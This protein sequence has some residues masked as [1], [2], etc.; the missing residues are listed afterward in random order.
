MI[1][2]EDIKNNPDIREYIEAADRSLL[3]LGF[4]EH[5]FSHTTRASLRP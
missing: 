3:A 2:F 4:T 5:G 1:K